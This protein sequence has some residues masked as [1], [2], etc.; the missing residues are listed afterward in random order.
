M[1]LSKLKVAPAAVRER[2]PG[3]DDLPGPDPSGAMPDTA[4]DVPDAVPTPELPDR[5][6]LPETSSRD[7]LTLGLTLLTVVGALLAVI[8]LV[9]RAVVKR[10]R[11]S[12]AVDIEVTDEEDE[13]V[14]EPE[15]EYPKVAP[16]VG[17]A[18]LVAMRLFVNRLRGED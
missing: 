15:R 14:P 17:M 12:T 11:T 9:G 10:R 18:A 4:P 13:T 7:K 2:L 6:D 3:G 1:V 8:G 5:D 16:L